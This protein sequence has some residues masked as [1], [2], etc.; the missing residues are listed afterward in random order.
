MA[1]M[2]LGPKFSLGRVVLSG[3]SGGYRVI[4]GILERGGLPATVK[5]VWLFDA[6]Y[7]ET[8]KF[9]AW[10][11]RAHGRLLNIYTD[12]GG[13]KAECEAMMALLKK[14]GTPFLAVEE[15]QLTPSGLK[16]NRLVAQRL[17]AFE[18]SLGIGVVLVVAA[19]TVAGDEVGAAVGEVP[20]APLVHSF[21]RVDNF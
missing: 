1:A 5:E 2:D 8:D 19:L 10:A 11:D 6:L 7:A 12:Q 18:P 20:P 14:R 3:H 9:L 21:V 4:A 17:V 15:S 13:T 16:S